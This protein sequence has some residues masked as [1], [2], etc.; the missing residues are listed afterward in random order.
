MNLRLQEATMK[1]LTVATVALYVNDL[2]N[3]E[4]R[5]GN[6]SLSLYGLVGKNN[7][8]YKSMYDLSLIN[9]NGT[10]KIDLNILVRCISIE[11]DRRIKNGT[12]ERE[13]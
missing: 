9:E 2:S 1:I 4:L 7:R 3:E 5:A 11:I 12:W 8:G 13:G 10:P 6:L